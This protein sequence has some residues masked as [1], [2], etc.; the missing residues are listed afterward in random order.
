VDAADFLDE[1]WRVL[2]PGG[3]LGIVVPDTREIMR[4]YVMDDPAPLEWPSGHHRDLR[5]LDELCT[6]VIYSTMQPSHHQ[7]AYDSFT[8]SRALLGAGFAIIGEIDRFTDSR[9][10]VPA[11]YQCGVSAIKPGGSA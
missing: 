1:C 3:L 8:L 4:R 2:E 5:D 7:W 6:A 9:I 10:P 11:W